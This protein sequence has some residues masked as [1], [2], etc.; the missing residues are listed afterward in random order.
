MP[1][2]MLIALACLLLTN[3]AAVIVNAPPGKTVT[4]LSDE[5]T[6][7]HIAMKNWYLLWGLIPLTPNSTATMIGQA[8]IASVRVKSYYRPIDCLENILLGVLTLHTNTVLLEGQ[9][10]N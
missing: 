10:G 8:N 4:L 6:Q 5:P 3:C 7:V 1:R 2:L 9:S